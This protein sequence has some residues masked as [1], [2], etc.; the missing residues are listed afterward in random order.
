MEAHG[1]ASTSADCGG[2]KNG[3]APPSRQAS[4]P[5]RV[6]FSSWCANG[7]V[8]SLAGQ[9]TTSWVLSDRARQG[10]GCESPAIGAINSAMNR[11]G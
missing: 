8:Q 7:S 10:I 3:V 2:D 5:K 11:A 9:G 1:N 6:G 4:S